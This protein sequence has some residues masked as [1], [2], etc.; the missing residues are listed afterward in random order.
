VDAT[1]TSMCGSKGGQALLSDMAAMI[2]VISMESD[3]GRS[4]SI[5]DA[6]ILEIDGSS[7]YTTLL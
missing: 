7:S 5:S 4:G 3:G 1:R 2:F 6:V